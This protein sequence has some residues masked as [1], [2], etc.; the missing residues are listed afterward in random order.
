MSK[1]IDY[2]MLFQAFKNGDEKAFEKV[3]ALYYERLCQYLLSYSQD[4]SQVEDV[5]Q[6]VFIGLWKKRNVLDIQTSLSGYLY[7]SAYN[8]MMDI[9]RSN[10]R[11]DTFLMNYYDMAILRAEGQEEEY[12]KN[13]LKRLKSCIERLPDRCQEVFVKSKLSRQTNQEVAN[14]FKISVKTVEGHISKGYRLLK[15]CIEQEGL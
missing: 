14:H 5:V 3:Y 15:E 9:Y 1:K 6:E 12:K 2:K 10:D 13:L 8:R 11:E 7:R 4:R